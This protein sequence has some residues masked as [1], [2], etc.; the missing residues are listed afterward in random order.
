MPYEESESNSESLSLKEWA[1]RFKPIKNPFADHP[2]SH[3]DYDS[4]DLDGEQLEFVQSKE[5][6][7]LVWTVSFGEGCTYL[8]NGYHYINRKNYFVCSVPYEKDKD[9]EIIVSTE[10]ECSCYS[11]NREIMKTRGE[12][13]GDPYCIKCK[14]SGL[15]TVHNT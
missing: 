2:T 11:D 15:V 9:Y 12:N 7:N 13:F 14:G 1:K 3:Q 6:E 10:E 5:I 8:S 4:F